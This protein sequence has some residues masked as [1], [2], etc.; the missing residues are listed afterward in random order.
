MFSGIGFA[1]MMVL[2]IVAVLL[3]GSRLP[4]VARNVGRSYGELRKGLTDLKSTVTAEI[5]DVERDNSRPRKLLDRSTKS[6]VHDDYD[7]PTAPRLDPE[8]P[9]RD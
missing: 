6:V 8:G 1:E 4:L 9:A 2:A 5:D 3:F 7:E